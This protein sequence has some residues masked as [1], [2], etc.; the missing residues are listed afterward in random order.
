MYRGNIMTKESNRG[1]NKNV[2]R[3][4]LKTGEQSISKVVRA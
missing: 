4:T 3:P 2:S 1:K